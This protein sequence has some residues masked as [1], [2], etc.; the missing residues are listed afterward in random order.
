MPKRLFLSL[1]MLLLLQRGMGQLYD[2]NWIVGD[3]AQI[4][5]FRNDSIIK[6]IIPQ[7]VRTYVFWASINDENGNFQFFTNGYNVFDSFGNQIQNGYA[8]IDSV[9]EVEYPGGLANTTGAIILPRSSQKYFYCNLSFS[10]S[11]MLSGNAVAPDRLY[12]AEI[13]MN[14]NSGAGAVI[15]K[16][17]LLYDQSM[18][19]THITA[20]RHGNGR[21]WWL[22]VNN[23]LDSTYAKFIVT[24]DTIIG[25]Y[26]QTIG[27]AYPAP[28]I[29]GQIQFSPDGSKMAGTTEESQL[30]IMDFDRCSG[31]F[32]NPV[33]FILPNDT[34][35]YYGSPT[36]ISSGGISVMFS[37]S[38]RYLYVSRQRDLLQYDLQSTDIA[39]SE[40]IIFG[41]GV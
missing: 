13:D 11:I 3:S 20:C 15:S 17:N 26:L 36:I 41:L 34:F 19:N 7:F 25:P 24:P 30:V 12:Y 28:D 8:L 32:S 21:D 39:A 5:A 38:G 4:F 29:A 6:G 9:E 33:S 16:R 40:K 10:D 31:L 2:Q 23:Y 14:A 37:P 35:M 18:T 27:P 22:V 1:F